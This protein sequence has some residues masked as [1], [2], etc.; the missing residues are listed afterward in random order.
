MTLRRRTEMGA[1][2]AIDGGAGGEG[3]H[4]GDSQ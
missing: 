3:S 4:G 2:G 1:C